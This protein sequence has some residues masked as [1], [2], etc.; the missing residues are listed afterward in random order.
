MNIALIK[1]LKNKCVRNIIEASINLLVLGNK[2]KNYRQNLFEEMLSYAGDEVYHQRILEIGPKDG[3]DTNRLLTLKPKELCVIDLPNKEESNKL[4]LKELKADPIKYF[5]GNIMYDRFFEEGYFNLIWFTGVLYHNPEQLRMIRLLYDLL[6][7]KGILVIES[8]TTKERSLQKKNVVQINYPPLDN[9]KK[10]KHIS[11]NVTHLPSRKA[12]W[13]WLS[14]VGFCDINKSICH[15]KQSVFLGRH[16]IAYI[17]RRPAKKD[18]RQGTYYAHT[19][20]PYP[21]G[22]SL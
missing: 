9:Y 15:R 11:H 2:R 6:K 20:S 22:K 12:V 7:P 3:Q 19:I 8:A 5:S 13:S 18:P 1:K 21:V 16:R 14:M 10:K 4:W 17:C